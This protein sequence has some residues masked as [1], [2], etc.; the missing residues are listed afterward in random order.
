MI[1]RFINADAPEL[2]EMTAYNVGDSNLFAYCGNNPVA[3]I[4]TEGELFWSVIAGAAVGAAGEIIS[5]LISG[6]D[7]DINRVVISAFVGGL[8]ATTG[9]FKIKRKELTQ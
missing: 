1:C 5:S 4:D 8:T 3:H 6:S 7:I 9:V 2:S